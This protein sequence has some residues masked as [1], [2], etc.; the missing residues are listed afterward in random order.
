MNASKAIGSKNYDIAID[1][2]KKR[3]EAD[4][5]DLFALSMIAHCYDWKG[6]REIALKY[7]NKLLAQDPTNFEMLLLAARYWSHNNNED[8]TYSYACRALENVPHSKPDDIPIWVY[9]LLKFLSIFKRFK[10]LES[11]VKESGLKYEKYHK[12]SIEWAW[13]YKKWYEEKHGSTKEGL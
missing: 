1:I 2:Y 4:E 13:Q 5:S 6:D 11:R 8:Q 10:R 9:W 12:D 3:L 7:A